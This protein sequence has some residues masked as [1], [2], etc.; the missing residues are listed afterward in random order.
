M[1]DREDRL[2]HLPESLA[3]MAMVQDVVLSNVESVSRYL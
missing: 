2:D 1:E 3:G